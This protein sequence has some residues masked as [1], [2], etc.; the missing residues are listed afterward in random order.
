MPTNIKNIQFLV[1]CSTFA[2]ILSILACIFIFPQIYFET[3]NLLNEVKGG[4][5]IFKV[6]TD[7]A[8]N[9]L[10][11]IQIRHKPQSVNVREEN[12]FESIFQRAKRQN[13]GK[14]PAWC[15]CEPIKPECPPGPEGPPGEP[16]TDGPPGE[17]GPNGEDNTQ[18][19]P[20]VKCEAPDVSKCIECPAG[21]PGEQGPIG[22]LGSSGQTG[23]A[24][25]AGPPAPQGK[26]GEQ[27]PP[28]DQGPPGEKGNPGTP[29]TPG[30]DTEH[31]P[32]LPGP[33]VF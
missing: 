23:E 30:S 20:Q 19:Y 13:Y 16:G 15:Q 9:L 33:K 27:G 14:L 25:A 22:P 5:E 1:Y 24:G 3:T 10:I 29:G 28:G 21:P 32:A 6:E 11:D 7:S 17:P 18:V 8:W 12:P 31:S 26:P 2:S 4:V